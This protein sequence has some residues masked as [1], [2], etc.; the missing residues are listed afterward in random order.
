MWRLKDGTC[1]NGSWLF[2]LGLFEEGELQSLTSG[3]A[4]RPQWRSR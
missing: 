4:L 3:L 2:A 1:I